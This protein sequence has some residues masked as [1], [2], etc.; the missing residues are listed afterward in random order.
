MSK[1][2]KPVC[3]VDWRRAKFAL[4]GVLIA[5]AILIWTYFNYF[6]K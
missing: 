6:N 2:K 1:E 4:A 3:V 5:L